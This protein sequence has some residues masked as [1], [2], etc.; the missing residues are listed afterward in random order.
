MDGEE[1]GG[2][3]HILLLK[4]Q[5]LCKGFYRPNPGLIPNCK[6]EDKV[7]KLEELLWDDIMYLFSASG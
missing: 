5:L 1:M 2:S 4:T 7:L 3:L 6:T